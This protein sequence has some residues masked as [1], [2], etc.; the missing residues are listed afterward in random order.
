M[1]RDAWYHHGPASITHRNIT[2]W[3]LPH[4]EYKFK[5]GPSVKNSELLSIEHRQST[6]G[7]NAIFTDEHLV[8]VFPCFPDVAFNNCTL[9]IDRTRDSGIVNCYN[10]AFHKGKNMKRPFPKRNVFPLVGGAVTDARYAEI[11]ERVFRGEV[12]LIQ[13]LGDSSDTQPIPFIEE[14]VFRKLYPAMPQMVAGRHFA[15]GH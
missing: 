13:Y 4:R 9:D 2:Y 5:T 6:E 3:R 15:T 7:G 14:S 8:F 12:T 1:A 10:P 11:I